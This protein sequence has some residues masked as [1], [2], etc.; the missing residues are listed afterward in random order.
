MILYICLS[1]Q[2]LPSGL[3][4]D[5]NFLRGIRGAVDFQFIY[6]LAEWMGVAT[7]KLLTSGP[8]T[9]KF[10]GSLSMRFVLFLHYFYSLQLFFFVLAFLFSCF[11]VVLLSN[12]E[13]YVSNSPVVGSHMFSTFCHLALATA[14]RVGIFPISVYKQGSQP[15]SLTSLRELGSVHPGLCSI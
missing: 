7:P 9:G 1:H 12:P 14:M 10:A 6:F 15:Q 11:I 5:L 3:Y 4:P 8:E 2:F 13:P